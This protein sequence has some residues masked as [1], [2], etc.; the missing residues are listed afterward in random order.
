MLVT[1]EK[2]VL[3]AFWKIN[4]AR[5]THLTTHRLAEIYRKHLFY[6]GY[7]TAEKCR[8]FTAIAYESEQGSSIKM[9]AM[10][11]LQTAEVKLACKLSYDDKQAV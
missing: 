8:L 3:L 9:A 10:S 5:R 2:G 4:L 11:F 1:C 7:T 6:G